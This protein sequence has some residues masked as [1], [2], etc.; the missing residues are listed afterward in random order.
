MPQFT[1]KF[2]LM[3]STNWSHKSYKYVQY[4]TSNVV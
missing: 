4:I 2:I 3:T 1:S